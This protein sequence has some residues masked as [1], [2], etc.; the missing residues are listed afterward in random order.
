MNGLEYG[1][2]KMQAGERPDLG[3]MFGETAEIR[4]SRVEVNQNI[5]AL[6]SA[7]SP[8]EIARLTELARQRA[9]EVMVEIRPPGQPGLDIQHG[10]LALVDGKVRARGRAAAQ[11]TGSVRGFGISK[12]LLK[13]PNV[14]KEDLMAIPRIIREFEPIEDLNAGHRGRTWVVERPDGRNLVVGEQ[15]RIEDGHG[16][17]STT[18]LMDEDKPKPPSEKRRP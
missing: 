17:L 1:L 12:V 5:E 18:H 2:R 10:P 14:D 6:R 3:R 15:R 16:F 11:E 13:H 7:Q 4:Q 8:E 9:P